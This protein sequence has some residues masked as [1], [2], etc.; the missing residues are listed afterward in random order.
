[1]GSNGRAA[2]LVMGQGEGWASRKWMKLEAWE[3]RMA[4]TGGWGGGGRRKQKQDERPSKHES[5]SV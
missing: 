3:E 4:D 1:M 5:K 2:L